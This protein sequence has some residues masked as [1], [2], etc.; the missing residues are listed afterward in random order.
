[1]RYSR[2]YRGGQM[3][4]EASLRKL[5]KYKVMRGLYS[6]DKTKK[7][8]LNES[9]M[10]PF[11]LKDALEILLKYGDIIILKGETDNAMKYR[12]TKRGKKKLAYYEYKYALYKKWVP[13]YERNTR[14]QQDYESEMRDIILNSNYYRKK[15]NVY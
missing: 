5:N 14:W 4:K 11:Q 15:T 8:L 7:D 12:L 3:V 10:H 1:M 13:P 9:N 2:F 6:C